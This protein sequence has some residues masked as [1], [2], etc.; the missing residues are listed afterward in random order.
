[1]RRS[2]NLIWLA[3]NCTL[4]FRPLQIVDSRLELDLVPSLE[5][6]LVPQ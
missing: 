5:L 3:S 4:S 6:D 2:L 1:M